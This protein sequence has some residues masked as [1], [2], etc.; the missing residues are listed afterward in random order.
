MGYSRP[1]QLRERYGRVC[2]S[3]AIRLRGN[4]GWRSI[5]KV[6]LISRV[7]PGAD[8]AV[9]SV[10]LQAAAHVLGDAEIEFA[11]PKEN[12]YLLVRGRGVTR[13]QVS[14]CRSPLLAD[15]LRA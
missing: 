6:V 14:Y 13:R 12:G 7:E 3:K 4:A 5:R 15:R 11:G 2:M 9:S 8:V 10:L 1:E